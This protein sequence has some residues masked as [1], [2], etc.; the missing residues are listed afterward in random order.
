MSASAIAIEGYRKGHAFKSFIYWWSYLRATLQLAFQ[1]DK[2]R[3]GDMRDSLGGRVR[4]LV[5]ADFL[6]EENL[7]VVASKID[8][9]L[10]PIGRS[11]DSLMSA[12]GL[13]S[14]LPIGPM[15]YIV[16][17]VLFDSF[18][19]W[20]FR[21]VTTWKWSTILLLMIAVVVGLTAI[22]YFIK[23]IAQ[24]ASFVLAHRGARGLFFILGAALFLLSKSFT[25]YITLAK[26]T[27]N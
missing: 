2:R 8:R 3:I 21:G 26:W 7:K 1:C 9:L 27:L 10:L 22:G 11:I 5:A 19:F 24:G 14:E 6:G 20:H 18:M 13:G 12:F 15:A 17:A 4:F 23:L 25:T 16:I